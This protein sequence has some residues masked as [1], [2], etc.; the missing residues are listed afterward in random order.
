MFLTAICLNPD[1]CKSLLSRG[2]IRSAGSVRAGR[3]AWLDPLIPGRYYGVLPGSGRA[4]AKYGRDYEQ[5]C[6]DLAVQ[7]DINQGFGPAQCRRSW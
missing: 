3:P 2:A 4:G 6:P 5:A 7:P 1:R